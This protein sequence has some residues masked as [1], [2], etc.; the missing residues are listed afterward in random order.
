MIPYKLIAKVNRFFQAIQFIQAFSKL[1][2]HLFRLIVSDPI[3]FIH[4]ALYSRPTHHFSLFTNHFS[5]SKLLQKPHIIA[6]EITDVANVPA[7]HGDA[8]RSHAKGKSTVDFRIITAIPQNVRV[9]HSASQDLQPAGVLADCA[10][11]AAAQET[12]HIHFR[13]WFSKGE[14]GWAETGADI[15]A[16]QTPAKSDRVPFRSLKVTF[17]PTI[18]PS[19]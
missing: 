4:F 10:A 2:H 13:G 3:I 9:N 19:T 11:L 6:P 1:I 18:N 12:F 5:F 16:E 17:L 15:L 7:H 8:F 14:V